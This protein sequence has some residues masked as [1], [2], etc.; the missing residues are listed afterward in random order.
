MADNTPKAA[1]IEA[2]QAHP[3]TSLVEVGP[4]AVVSRTI[5][6][7]KGGT[8]TMFAFDTGEGL[9]EHSAPFDAFVQ[10]VDGK[11]ELTIGGKAVTAEPGTLVRMPAD[12]PHALYAQA[13]TRM[14]LI[15][16]RDPR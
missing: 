10:V 15:M 4:G 11:L 5:A 13:P 8:L 9:S 3:L 16:L 6:K 14:L 7:T 12:V 2:S 1:E